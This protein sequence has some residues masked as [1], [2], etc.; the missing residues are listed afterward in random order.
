MTNNKNNLTKY[1]FFF[2]LS[3]TIYYA[4]VLAFLPFIADPKLSNF[5]QYYRLWNWDLRQHARGDFDQDGQEDLIS[6]TGCAFL[7]A[8]DI[9]TIPESKRCTA[10]GIASMFVKSDQ[11]LVGQK[12]IEN[13]KY[14]LNLSTND[15]KPPVT[16]SY[17]GK[18]K[19]ANW[20]IY[21]N[22]NKQL[23]SYQIE[24]NGQLSEIQPTT[25][26]NKID[27]FLYSISRFFVLLALPLVPLIII[28]SPIFAPFRSIN[29]L[30]PIYEI[31]TLSIITIILF[32]IWKKKTKSNP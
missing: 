26:I 15:Q 5:E 24:K 20:K 27:E 16:H 12:Y 9:N 30:M 25:I 19:D 11:E 32:F 6:F 1:F 2:F 3:L 10:I 21:I 7:S 13:E 31:T 28:F 23:K 22:E 17:L 14:D 29:D 8:V 4:F 18:Y